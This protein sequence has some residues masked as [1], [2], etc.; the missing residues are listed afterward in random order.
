MIAVFYVASGTFGCAMDNSGCATFLDGRQA[1]QESPSTKFD[2]VPQR[3]DLVT[4]LSIELS[5]DSVLF[6]CFAAGFA[7]SIA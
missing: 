3:P 4:I 5:S 1:N 2:L 7:K 6:V